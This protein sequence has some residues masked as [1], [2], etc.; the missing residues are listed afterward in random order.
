LN[1]GA[2]ETDSGFNRFLDLTCES[3]RE[4]AAKVAKLKF[5]GAKQVVAT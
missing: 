3:K 1:P 2:R 4:F 5:Q